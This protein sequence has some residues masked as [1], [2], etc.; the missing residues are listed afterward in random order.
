VKNQLLNFYADNE[1]A[2]FKLDDQVATTG[3]LLRAERDA[4]DDSIEKGENP[5][6]GLKARVESLLTGTA[7]AT[8]KTNA[9]RRIEIL[10][11]ERDVEQERNRL[12]D[13]IRVA[14]HAAGERL[15]KHNKPATEA[16]EKLV[17]EKFLGFYDAYYASWKMRRALLNDGIGL[18][19]SFNG[20]SSVD[21]ALGIPVDTN[22]RWADLFRDFIAA[23]HIRRM[24]PA[25][26]PK[27]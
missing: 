18:Y 12:A 23:N 13:K 15:A 19:G 25:L 11:A 27:S 24:P 20:S 16:A 3:K 14:N 9:E 8:P 22:S 10:Y 4:I 7:L 21:D 17:A 5:D 6:P 2:D 1:K 26:L